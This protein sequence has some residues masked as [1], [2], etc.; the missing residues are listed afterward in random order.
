MMHGDGKSGS[1]IA[2]MKPTKQPAAEQSAVER[3]AAEL[4][5][6]RAEANS[7]GG[8]FPGPICWDEMAAP[9]VPSI[10]NACVGKKKPGYFSF[11]FSLLTALQEKA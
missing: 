11:D 2:A 6:P 5:E 7:C 3:S 10:K 9:I 1:A 8:R 4:V